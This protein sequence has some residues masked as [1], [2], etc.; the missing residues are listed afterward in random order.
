MSTHKKS[1]HAFTHLRVKEHKQAYTI[2]KWLTFKLERNWFS[3][4]FSNR[5]GQIRK[6]CISNQKHLLISS[7]IYKTKYLFS[8]PETRFRSAF[9]TVCAVAQ[10]LSQRQSCTAGLQ[11]LWPRHSPLTSFLSSL[12]TASCSPPFSFCSLDSEDRR[13]QMCL[14]PACL[15][16]SPSWFC[17]QTGA[18]VSSWGDRRQAGW[19]Q[20]ENPK[21]KLYC[22]LSHREEAASSTRRGCSLQEPGPHR[23]SSGGGGWRGGEGSNSIWWQSV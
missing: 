10:R 17:L 1:W 7:Q 18:R 14:N 9:H 23:K 16:L 4:R 11:R 2:S 5:K 22:P 15:R 8:E 3:F 13:F 20:A 12:S 19:A 21:E 6:K